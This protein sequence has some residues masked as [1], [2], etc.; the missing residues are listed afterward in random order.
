MTGENFTKVDEQYAEIFHEIWALL[1][2]T[3]TEEGA[4]IWLNSRNR[5]LGMA[6]P[7][8]LINSARGLEARE[9]AYAI[10]GGG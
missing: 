8:D 6:K 7:I 2:E 9:A 1:K 10:E 3:Y 4:M 5:G